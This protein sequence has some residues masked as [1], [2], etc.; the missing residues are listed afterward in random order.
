MAQAMER[1]TNDGR[2]RPFD[3]IVS[4][5]SRPRSRNTARMVRRAAVELISLL[6]ILGVLA[7]IQGLVTLLDGRRAVQHLRT[8][9]PRSSRRPEVVVLCPCRGVD[10][11]FQKNIASIRDQDYPAFTT[12]FIVDSADDPAY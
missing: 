1:Q 9:R 3:L 6:Y 4:G 11:E 10:P 12:V 5:F 2:R 8:F 7:V